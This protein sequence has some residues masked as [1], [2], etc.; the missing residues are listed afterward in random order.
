RRGRSWTSPMGEGLYLSVI[1]RPPTPL[2]DV[3][4]IGFVASLAVAEAVEQTAGVRPRI[5]WPNDILLRNRKVAGVLVELPVVSPDPVDKEQHAVVHLSGRPVVVGV[6][7]NVNPTSFPPELQRSATSIALTRGQPVAVSDVERALLVSLDSWYSKY[8]EQGFEPV[9]KAWKN[10]DCTVGRKVRIE[11]DGR[12]IEGLVKQVR[13][14][15]GDI[16]VQCSDDT[17]VTISAGDILME[18]C[19]PD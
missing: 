3:W 6:G 18:E 13:T 8:L 15:S 12:T 5:K 9:M 11:L 10:L 17:T 14:T 19:L 2:T 1:L 7:V 16:V 4:Q